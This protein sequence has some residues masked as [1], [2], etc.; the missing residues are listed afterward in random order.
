M[1]VCTYVLLQIY[2]CLLDDSNVDF[3]LTK[4]QVQVESAFEL[5]FTTQTVTVTLVSNRKLNSHKI[6]DG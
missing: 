6:I 1:Y 5:R 3:M 4:E 2:I